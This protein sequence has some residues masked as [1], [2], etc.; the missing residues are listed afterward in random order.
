M[1]KQTRFPRAIDPA[2]VGKYPGL[3]HAGG[4]FVWDAF[5]PG[6]EL[7]NYVSILFPGGYDRFQRRLI[8]ILSIQVL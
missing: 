7:W 8:L 1:K 5:A 4:G 6:R 3:C 2:R